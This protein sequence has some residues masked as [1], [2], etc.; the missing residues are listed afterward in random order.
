M[1]FL[2]LEAAEVASRCHS[3][4]V[5]N[6]LYNRPNNNY[7]YKNNYFQCQ[8]KRWPQSVKKTVFPHPQTMRI[9]MSIIQVTSTCHLVCY[10]F[11]GRAELSIVLIIHRP[12]IREKHQR[13]VK[14]LFLINL[15]LYYNLIFSELKAVVVTRLSHKYVCK[16]GQIIHSVHTIIL[17]D[18]HVIAKTFHFQRGYGRAN[19][20]VCGSNLCV[21]LYLFRSFDTR[22]CFHSDTLSWFPIN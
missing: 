6:V 20:Q 5:T 18:P 17:S 11:S 4:G 12:K 16:L 9:L 19:N 14:R 3:E 1:E 13:C 22:R 10:C 8:R 7:C 15:I 2:D 21:T